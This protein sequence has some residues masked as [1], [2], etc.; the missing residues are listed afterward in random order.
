MFWIIHEI[1]L[2]LNRTAHATYSVNIYD[3]FSLVNPT[4]SSDLVTATGKEAT[5]GMATTCRQPFGGPRRKAEF[6]LTAKSYIRHGNFASMR[7][8]KSPSNVEVPIFV[9]SMTA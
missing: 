5:V 2:N 7:E 8:L 3:R 6:N 9:I 4:G 1:F